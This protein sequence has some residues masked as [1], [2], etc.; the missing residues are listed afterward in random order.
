MLKPINQLNLDDRIN[1]MYQLIQLGYELSTYAAAINWSGSPNSR[2]YLEGLQE[3]IEAYQDMYTALFG[4][5][6]GMK[7]DAAALPFPRHVMTFSR[8]QV[9]TFHKGLAL[10]AIERYAEKVILPPDAFVWIDKPEVDVWYDF[11][12]LATQKHGQCKLRVL[13]WTQE[14]RGLFPAL[15]AVRGE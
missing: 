13:G 4:E 10:Q 12:D 2:E 6:K 3:K 9:N 14:P 1:A 15:M 5:Q 8:G 11:Y 7:V